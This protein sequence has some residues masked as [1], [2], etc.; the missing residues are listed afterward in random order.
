MPRPSLVISR[1]LHL[2]EVY[3]A[4]ARAVK[5]LLRYDRIGVV[6][7]EG[8]SGHGSFGCRAPAGLLAG[9]SLGESEGT[10]VDWVLKNDKPFV[11]RD[12]T[13][14]SASRISTFIAKEGFERILWSPCSPEEQQS[15]CSSWT[16]LPAA[17]TPSR[18]SHW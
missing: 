4:F 6:V 12:L 8:K 13:A 14:S 15:G 11:V 1:S 7:P 9:T 3:P 18:T 16:A 5:A 17:P 2:S 10:A